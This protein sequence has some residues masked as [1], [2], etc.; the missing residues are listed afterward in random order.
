[1][2]FVCFILSP[3]ARIFE[4]FNSV[5]REILNLLGIEV[6][7]EFLAWAILIAGFFAVYFVL[8]ALSF[9]ILKPLALTLKPFKKAAE[10]AIGV[11]AF[12]II[13]LASF[14][15]FYSVGV[16]GIEISGIP[17]LP[18]IQNKINSFLA[19]EDVA[20]TFNTFIF[21]VLIFLMFYFIFREVAIFDSLLIKF[22][23]AALASI[24]FS[25]SE[26]GRTFSS[27]LL[28]NFWN[29]IAFLILIYLLLKSWKVLRKF[30]RHY[31]EGFLRK[32]Y[33]GSRTRI[34][35]VLIFIG[36]SLL[37][38]VLF[39]FI[40]ILFELSILISFALG[41]IFGAL[42]YLVIKYEF[43]YYP[44]HRL[45]YLEKE[46]EKID[47]EIMKLFEETRKYPE[48]EQAYRTLILVLDEK[49]AYLNAKIDEAKKRIEELESF[50]E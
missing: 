21:P 7:K 29:I 49:R 13:F 11:T 30:E 45:E 20:F 15:L 40:A 32:Y 4:L 8:Y 27:N 39:A 26:I 47:K 28:K 50:S 25:F 1:M 12:L 36:I 31:Y 43:Y 22:G 14:L 10:K 6:S 19:E 46:R 18:E 23:L 48:K 38:G 35:S 17:N 16:C 44:R 3:I 37:Y 24:M 2:S 5:I 42:I 34:V 33:R 41:A 9:F